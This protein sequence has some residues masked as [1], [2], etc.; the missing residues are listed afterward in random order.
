MDI[1]K[2]KDFNFNIKIA[3][4]LD[5]KSKVLFLTTFKRSNLF[6]Y[7]QYQESIKN[8]DIKIMVLIS[9]EI[10]I[11]IKVKKVNEKLYL[12]V[13]SIVKIKTFYHLTIWY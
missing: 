8:I 13:T 12:N 9:F 1:I 6:P 2:K 10:K 11:S 5:G 3:T 4:T 7:I